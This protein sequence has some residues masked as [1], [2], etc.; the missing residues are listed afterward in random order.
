MQRQCSWLAAPV[1]GLVASLLAST[2]L[3][4]E[5]EALDPTGTWK[6]E[7]T[8]RDRTF[9]SAL[10]LSLKDDKVVATL[11]RRGEDVEIEKTKL[12][13]DT[14][15]FQYTRSWDDRSVTVKFSGKI[16]ED[17]IKGHVDW[18]VGDQSGT[19]DWEAR[20]V[21][22]VA[23]VLGTWKFEL[24]MGDGGRMEPSITITQDGEDLRGAFNSRFGQRDARNV[25]LENNVL[26]FE[27]SGDTDDSEFLVIY[28]GKPRGD[29]IAGTIEY[30]FGGQTGSIDFK[31]RRQKEEK[32]TD[33]DGD[34]SRD[35][36]EDD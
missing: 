4:A 8:R 25:K 29:A 20:R 23:D 21:V 19:R 17:A 28:R 14:L 32:Q 10:R 9:E 13:G 24:E 11:E 27:I 30:D 34:K 3:A 7:T 18:T 15:S 22:E 35:E 36:E 5:E 2:T 26:T 31:G 6:W 12:D 1:L 16:S 33:D